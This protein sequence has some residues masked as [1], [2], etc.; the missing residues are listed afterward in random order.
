MQ[1]LNDN[2]LRDLYKKLDEAVGKKDTNFLEECVNKAI[3]EENN[4]KR[5]KKAVYQY[6]SL[7]RSEIVK[8]RE[9]EEKMRKSK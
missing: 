2:D 7:Y 3:S 6:A 8:I 1:N 5:Y 9:L 4:D